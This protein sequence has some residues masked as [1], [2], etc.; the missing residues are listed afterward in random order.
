MRLREIFGEEKSSV[1]P[2][3][4]GSDGLPELRLHDPHE[5]SGAG[6]RQTAADAPDYGLGKEDNQDWELNGAHS[7]R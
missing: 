2:F 7:S 3:R 1:R 6:I 4:D 5:R